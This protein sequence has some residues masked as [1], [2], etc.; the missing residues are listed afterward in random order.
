V[1]SWKEIREQLIKHPGVDAEDP[2]VFHILDSLRNNS[3]AAREGIQLQTI[4]LKH[5][6]SA[7]FLE[8]RVTTNFAQA[9]LFA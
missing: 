8:G 4:L 3:S 5:F 1:N 2:S 6:E 9:M 7:T